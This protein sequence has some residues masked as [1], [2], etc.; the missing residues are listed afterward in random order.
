LGIGTA[1]VGAKTICILGC[2]KIGFM[3]TT[4]YVFA[5]LFIFTAIATALLI[6]CEPAQQSTSSTSSSEDVLAA[7]N[8]DHWVFMAEQAMPLRGRTRM[9]TGG[10]EVECKGDTLISYLPYFGRAYSTTYGSTTSALDFKS[11]NFSYTKEKDAK[12]AWNVT[13]KPADYKEVQ[14]MYFTFYENGSAQLNVQSNNREAIS[15]SGSVAKR[16]R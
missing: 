13:I 14:V 10:Y 3:K 1:C 11:T 9:I 6:S 12:G 16:K 2:L 4:M 7:I 15:F 8:D 5:R